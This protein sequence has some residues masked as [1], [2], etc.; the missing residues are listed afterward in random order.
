MMIEDMAESRKREELRQA[1]RHSERA[2]I[3]SLLRTDGALAMIQAL[4]T[5]N[6]SPLGAASTAL[7]Q[8]AVYLERMRARRC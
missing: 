7:E 3:I 1:A 2:D 6:D 5:A 8:F 4:P